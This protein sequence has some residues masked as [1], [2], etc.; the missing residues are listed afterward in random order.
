MSKHYPE[1]DL[2]NIPDDLYTNLLK[3]ASFDNGKFED[4]LEEGLLDETLRLLISLAQ[5]LDDQLVQ[6]FVN[7][8]RQTPQEQWRKSVI[9]LRKRI[10]ARISEVKTLTKALHREQN[11][12][13]QAA[14]NLY[15]TLAWLL[16][17]ELLQSDR[18]HRLR[19]MTFKDGITALDWYELRAAQQKEK[20]N[21]RL[22]QTP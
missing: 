18:A 19:E 7:P 21:A 6:P 14:F 9:R 11:S 16:A 3:D 22:Q 13:A 12:S 20:Q 4:F 15:G 8:K 1:H 17:D 5:T 2:Y 10:D